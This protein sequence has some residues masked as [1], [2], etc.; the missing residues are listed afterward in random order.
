MKFVNVYST[1]ITKSSNNDTFMFWTNIHADGDVLNMAVPVTSL[2]EATCMVAHFAIHC[3]C[4]LPLQSGNTEVPLH[5]C[6]REA[7]CSSLGESSGD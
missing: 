2:T 5:A 1:Q 6:I 3:A 7:I 4:G